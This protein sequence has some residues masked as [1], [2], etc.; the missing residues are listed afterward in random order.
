MPD[1]QGWRSSSTC[2]RDILGAT[3]CH[4]RQGAAQWRS[5]TPFGQQSQTECS[6]RSSSHRMRHRPSVEKEASGAGQ[7]PLA[8]LSRVLIQAA[9]HS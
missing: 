4:G 3:R 6:Q 7:E 1:L 2:R 5:L 8:L 9:A